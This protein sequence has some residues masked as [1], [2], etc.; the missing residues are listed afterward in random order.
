ME[1]LLGSGTLAGPD[2]KEVP[3]RASDAVV[4]YCVLTNL[5]KYP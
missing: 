5:K 2:W 3:N 4:A 1:P